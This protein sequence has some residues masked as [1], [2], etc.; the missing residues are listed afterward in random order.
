MGTKRSALFYG[1]AALAIAA[2]LLGASIFVGMPVL[3]DLVRTVQPGTPGTLSVMLTDPPHVPVGVSAVFVTYSNLGIHVSEAGNWSGWTKVSSGGTIDLLSTV[4]I[5]ETI[6]AARVPSGDYNALR[7]NVTSSEVTYLGKNYTAFVVNSR[8]T[9]PIVG[10]IEVSNSRPSA[11][12]IDISPLVVNIGSSSS[13]EFVIRTAAVAFPVPSSQ[14]TEEMEHEGFVFGLS[15]REWWQ[16][17]SQNLASLTITSASLSPSAFHVSVK[18][19]SGDT[20]VRLVVVSSYVQ[21]TGGGYSPMPSTL[22][23]TAVFVVL[24]NGTLV[25]LG[26][27]FQTTMMNES[28]SFDEFRTAFTI[29]G[30]N[31]TAGSSATFAY[32]GTI[33]LGFAFT[34]GLTHPVVSGQKYLVT[35]IGTDTIATQVVVAS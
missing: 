11:T 21:M 33:N 18:D 13:P 35:V 4:N 34:G 20:T 5:S 3:S 12:I 32:S 6:A 24:K 27:F 8:L 30:Y 31:L 26:Q 25:P 19:G 9:I 15:G 7:L 22:W 10:G 16:Q 1:G 29:T 23:G 28:Q 2:A 17:D 14:V